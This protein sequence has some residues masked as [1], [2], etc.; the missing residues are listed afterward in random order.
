MKN[1]YTAQ[2]P[3]ICGNLWEEIALSVKICN[4]KK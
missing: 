4:T 3:K 1:N 2:S